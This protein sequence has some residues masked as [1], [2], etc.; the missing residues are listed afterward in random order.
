MSR[1]S[2]RKP[3][4]G[5]LPNALFGRLSLEDAPGE[6]IGVAEALT[7]LFPW[8]SLLRA[9]AAPEVGNLRK[10]TAIG[11]PGA[12]I[13]FV[14]GYGAERDAGALEELGLPELGAPAAL[15][16]LEA[17]YAAAGLKM[18]ARYALREEVALIESTWAKKLAFAGRERVF[19]A[20][21][22][23]VDRNH[24]LART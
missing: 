11:K 3:S 8:G 21:E 22:G 5:G 17:A 16:A 18:S 10:L 24:A 13:S 15:R 2:L 23:T 19:V 20:L 9:L 1:R 7:V 14:Y 6:L 12:R 4:R